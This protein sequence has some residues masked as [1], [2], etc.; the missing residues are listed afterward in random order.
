MN[1]ESSHQNE[2]LHNIKIVGIADGNL[3]DKTTWSGCS[4]GFFTA[5]Q[6]I[7]CLYAGISGLPPQFINRFY[8]LKNFSWGLKRWK[9]KYHIDIAYFEAMT[10]KVKIEL[11]KLNDNF[12][13]IIQVFS[14]YDVPLIIENKNVVTCAFQDGNLIRRLNNPFGHPR[15]SPR[16]IDKAMQRE[17]RIFRRL[18]YI[19]TFSE[20]LRQ[21]FINDYNIDSDRIYVVGAGANIP[22]PEINEKQKFDGRT[23]LFIGIDFERKGGKILLEAFRKVKAELSDARLIIIGP[24]L[25]DLPDG[26]ECL[27][28]ISKN[29]PEG[30]KR[31]KQAYSDASVFTM[32]SLYEPFGVVFLEAMAYG[33]P[34]IG[35]DNCAMPEI[36]DHGKTG[37]LVQPGDSE[38]LADRIVELL[39]DFRLAKKMGDNGLKKVINNFTWAHVANRVVDTLQS[40]M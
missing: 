14:F 27:G 18:D 6:K 23:I 3:F 35:A 40:K 22:I 11:S 8:Q 28:Y 25:K 38:N 31:L 15:I 36:I 39:K 30:L 10:R 19:F 4:Y 16:L 2:K 26:V 24:N 32:P 1:N 29:T 37:F 5:I 20:W 12:T 33:L 17:I 9:F 13:H 34:C 7:G 21:S